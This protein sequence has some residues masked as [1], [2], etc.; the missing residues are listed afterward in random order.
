[1]HLRIED[2]VVVGT[3]DVLALV[4]PVQQPISRAINDLGNAIATS[5]SW[6]VSKFHRRASVETGADQV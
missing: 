6:Q 3:L 5:R 2:Q 1:M 4:D